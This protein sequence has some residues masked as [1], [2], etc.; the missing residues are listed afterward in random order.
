MVEFE[1]K[2]TCGIIFMEIWYRASCKW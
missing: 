2:K 1:D